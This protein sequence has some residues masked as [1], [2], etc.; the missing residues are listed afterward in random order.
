[1]LTRGQSLGKFTVIEQ[2]G[3]GGMGEVYLAEDT[4]LHRQVAIKILHKDLFGDRERLDRFYLEARSAA[5]ISHANVMAIYDLES[6]T[7]ASGEEVTYIV[8]EYVRGET[9]TSWLSK[10]GGDLNA[11]IRIG[12]KIASGLAAAHKMNI[13][14][15][16]IKSENIIITESTEPKILDFGLAKVI[17]SDMMTK[18]D[19]DVRT[20]SKELTRAGKI[21]GTVNYMSPEQARGEALDARSD[22]F[23]FGI[24]LYR[25][26][27]GEFPFAGVTDVST[28]AKILEVAHESP[29]LRNAS[30]PLELE[31]IIDK[32]LR[33][34]PG[35]R[36]QSTQDLVVDMRN[37][38]RQV[39]SGMSQSYSKPVD[40]IPRKS[41]VLNMGWKVGLAAL[42]II[43]FVTLGFKLFGSGDTNM[44]TPLIA[45]QG[46][47]AIIGFENKT[48]DTSLNWLSGGLPEI[49]LTDLAQNPQL[50][51]ISDQ[52][53]QDALNSNE[54]A[55]RINHDDY[56]AA[57]RKLG[58]SQMLSGSYFKM[59]DQV[60]IDA[61]IEDVASG[62]ISSAYKV[63]GRDP[64]GLVDSLSNK[65]ASALNISTH[66][67]V[68]ASSILSSSPDAYKHYLAGMRHFGVSDFDNATPE[69][70][71]AIAKDSTFA[72]PYMRLG[73][74]NAFQ[75]RMKPAADYLTQ[76]LRWQNKLP[77][78]ERALLDVYADAWLRRNWRDASTKLEAFIVQYPDDKE[79]LAL[80]G[81]FVFSF[82]GD[83]AKAIKSLNSA[84]KLDA[85]YSSA[86]GGFS[87]MYMR[88]NQFEK[89]V[90]YAERIRDASP[91]VPSGHLLLANLYTRTGKID[92]SIAEYQTVLSLAPR[93]GSALEGLS[94]IY[95]IKRQFDSSRHY[96][97]RLREEFR[98][99]PVWVRRYYKAL[100]N[101][102]NWEGRFVSALK[103]HFKALQYALKSHD[104][105]DI[106]NT[107]GN[108]ASMYERLEQGDSAVYYSG[109]KYK[110]RGMGGGIGYAFTL[111]EY[112][113][114]KTDSANAI[115]K[116]EVDELKARLPQTM[117]G[118]TDALEELFEGSKTHD[119]VRMIAAMRLLD[120]PS[121]NPSPENRRALAQM[122]IEH[123]ESREGI[124]QY[125]SSFASEKYILSGDEYPLYLYFV[126]KA[127]ENLGDK[128][129]A[130]RMYEEM[131][132]YWGEPEFEVK[133]IRDARLRLKQ[134]RES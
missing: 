67:D 50:R 28:L 112:M 62:K 134:L 66:S 22:I 52:R 73:M 56:V 90:E 96:L 75:G 24:L 83:T 34:E 57:A 111:V 95:I 19:A 123:G 103:K 89:A 6:A 82:A 58:V 40:I 128:A 43:T 17:D 29:R 72:L 55:G 91:K 47:L 133:E 109:M 41:T 33:K 14:H 70:L 30:I 93:T 16:D 53:L 86:L 39:D 119:S 59:G 25:M 110:S 1:M 80:H 11:V 60:R 27:S 124:A 76:A 2:L 21:M 99:D 54:G 15:R 20:V 26:V 71:A 49:L 7:I 13:V 61:R 104:S 74:A 81:V 45:G 120:N 78:R 51:L 100:A 63:V 32:C 117:W 8:M 102:D 118:L 113:P 97:E 85:D 23:S 116:L 31:R 88:L 10:S 122:L 35:D 18:H 131:L 107:Y 101:V 69:F 5:Q 68:N 106:A 42:V 36:Y 84:L 44:V 37:L 121:M 132:T 38:R 115:F 64:F 92:A 79:A 105:I 129:K 108:I 46:G 48:G 126:G 125:D 77:A 130:K 3:S 65:I 98:D 12:E 4:Q 94:Q 114:E 87:Q 9:L 127:W